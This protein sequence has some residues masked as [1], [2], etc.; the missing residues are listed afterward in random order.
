MIESLP[1]T[2]W[3]PGF[4]LRNMNRNW[5][6]YDWLWWQTPHLFGF[7]WTTLNDWRHLEGEI[8]TEKSIGLLWK[9]GCIILLD[10]YLLKGHPCGRASTASD[11]KMF[12]HFSWWQRQPFFRKSHTRN[13]LQ[14]PGGDDRGTCITNLNNAYTLKWEIPENL[15]KSPYM[16]IWFVL[17]GLLKVGNIWGLC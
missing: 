5:I 9:P 2:C 1:L 17:F 4:V 13:D 12:G 8:S 6:E 7:R 14:N 10:P 16:C 15:H 3:F 11:F